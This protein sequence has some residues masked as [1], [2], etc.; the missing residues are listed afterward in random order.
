LI[1]SYNF[2]DNTAGS[3]LVAFA[4]NVYPSQTCLAASNLTG[5]ASTIGLI[6]NPPGTHTKIIYKNMFFVDN[7]R[8]FTLRYAH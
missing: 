4:I 2:H 3:C 6:A 5:Y 7:G 1:D 8:A